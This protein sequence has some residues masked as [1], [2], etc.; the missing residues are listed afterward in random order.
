MAGLSDYNYQPTSSNVAREQLYSDLDLSFRIHPVLKDI[1]PVTDT[2]AIKNSLKNLIFSYVYSRPFKPYFMSD[3]RRLLF[4]PNTLFT[5]LNLKD[6]ITRIIRD[7]EPRVNKFDVTI[8]D[9]S[10]RNA[11]RII[12]TYET[13]YDVAEQTVFF[14]E[15]LR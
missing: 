3:I 9:E 8:E 7:H 13:S 2:D 14:I 4:E 1:V 5:R 10:D 12:I 15:R 6:T 11:Y